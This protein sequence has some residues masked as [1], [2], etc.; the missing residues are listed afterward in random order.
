LGRAATVGNGLA[1]FKAAGVHQFN[2]SAILGQEFSMSQIHSDDE[3]E[4]L[5]SEADS[6]HL[7]RGDSNAWTSDEHAGLGSR[8]SGA[9]EEDANVSTPLRIHLKISPVAEFPQGKESKWKQSATI[10]TSKNYLARKIS[11]VH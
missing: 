6:C 10:L 3:A 5:Q 2:P 11:E 7:V 8:E 9:D 4:Q 1:G